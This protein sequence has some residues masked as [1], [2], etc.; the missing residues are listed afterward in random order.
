M[1]SIPAGELE[2]KAYATAR[3]IASRSRLQIRASKEAMRVLGDAVAV[4]PTTYVYCKVYGVTSIFGK[5]YRE[6]IHA[7][8][9][10][11]PPESRE[12]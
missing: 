9:E 3:T 4:N 7:F 12:C 5:D 10:K 2:R 8:L 6:G 1:R 11:R